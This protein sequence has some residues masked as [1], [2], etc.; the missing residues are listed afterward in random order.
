[1]SIRTR[2]PG[3]RTAGRSAIAGDVGDRRT[4]FVIDAFDGR[5]SP[6]DADYLAM[7]VHWRPPHGRQ[8]MLVS[9]PW[10]RP[11][12]SLVSLDDDHVVTIPPTAGDPS[13]LRPVGW[14]P[15]GSSFAYQVWHPELEAHVTHLRDIE[16][17]QETLLR[18]A[19]GHISN[20]GTRIVGFDGKAGDNQLCVARTSGGPCVPIGGSLGFDPEHGAGLQW[21]PDDQSDP[22]A[23]GR[24]NAAHRPRR[25]VGRAAIVAAGRRR[26]LAADRRLGRNGSCRPDAKRVERAVRPRHTGHRRN[27]P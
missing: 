13:S 22:G 25:M 4:I 2:W 1:M 20:D 10:N 8:L 18:V 7:E 5:V 16:T 26:D 6:V 23:E 14:T 12:L 11:E 3:P 9:G 24:R 19:F 17:G 27:E 15:D 21:S